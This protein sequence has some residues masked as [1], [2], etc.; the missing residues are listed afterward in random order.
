M[1]ILASLQNTLMIIST[2]Y[3]VGEWSSKPYHNR[4][5]CNTIHIWASLQYTMVPYALTASMVVNYMRK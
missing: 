3:V 2:I 1:D 4:E 5:C